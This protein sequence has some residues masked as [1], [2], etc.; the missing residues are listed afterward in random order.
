MIQYH[1]TTLFETRAGAQSHRLSKFSN[2]AATW[3]LR[4][5][6]VHAPCPR[7]APCGKA[8]AKSPTPYIAP[9]P[10]AS[11]ISTEHPRP[12]ISSCRIAGIRLRSTTRIRE[13]CQR[14]P[15]AAPSPRA[16]PTRSI[17]IVCAQ[18][19]ARST[20]ALPRFAR[21]HTM[22]RPPSR[23]RDDACRFPTTCRE[24]PHHAPSAPLSCFVGP[25]PR[26]G[27]RRSRPALRAGARAGAPAGA[28]LRPPRRPRPPRR[29]QGCR[30]PRAPRSPRSGTR[31]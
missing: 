22:R 4:S 20:P 16:P 23:Q 8:Q 1:A 30:S 5:R 15:V 31:A 28:A 13:A 25:A 26:A 12:R 18:A 3:H 21:A 14:P 10:A 2:R 27:T 24:A 6:R 17:A 29:R 19:H 7:V 9:A 11:V